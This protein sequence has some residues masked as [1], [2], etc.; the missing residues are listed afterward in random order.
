MLTGAVG[1]AMGPA[2]EAAPA[3]TAL[4]GIAASPTLKAVVSLSPQATTVGHRVTASI[5]KSTLPKGDQTK[6]ITLSWG[7]HTKTVKLTSL[8]TKP[9]HLYAVPGRY[10]VVLAITDQKNRK[11]QDAKTEVVRAFLPPV[12][13]YTGADPRLDVVDPV[14]FYVSSKQ[15]A[16]QD[17]AIPYGYMTC[18]PDGANINQP[19]TIPAAAIKPDGSFTA[20]ATQ[21]G[22]YAGYPARFNDAFRGDYEGASTSGIA[23]LTGT[24]RETLTYSSSAKQACTSGNQT[25][26]ATRDAQPAQKASA[27]PAG[28]YTGSDPDYDVVDPITFYVSAKQ[29]ALQDISIPYGYMTCSPGGANTNQP[30]TIPT[31]AI[32]AGGSFSA[33]E[34]QTGVYAGDRATF[35][36]TFRGNFHSVAPSGAERA[37]GTFRETLTYDGSAAT[38]CTSNNQLWTATREAQPAQKALPPPSGSYTGS[39]PDYDVVDPITFDVASN[40]TALQNI[41]IPYG[42]MTCTPGGANINEPFTI[43]AA[44]IKADGSFSASVTQSG[45]YAN[46]PAT[47]TYTFRGNFH[48][49]GPSGAERAAGTFRETLTYDGSAATTCTSN[50]QLW[51]AS[52]TG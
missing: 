6:K 32:K 19:F 45:V 20:T 8:Q 21:S 38:T 29:N 15:T 2:S 44:A 13:S 27:P 43:V 50:N 52:R 23:T 37:A 46:Q 14:T 16:L 10:A 40:Q 18:A 26:T 51:T 1:V 24:F 48:S 28:S 9:T 22:V 17:I 4:S 11:V 39:D 36:Y 12:G 34:T 25:W 7:D 35:S 47:Y 41:S 42:Y 30:F 33:T 5:N 31:A 49:V 3:K